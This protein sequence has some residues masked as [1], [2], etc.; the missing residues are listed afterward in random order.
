MNLNK[1]HSTNAESSLPL[2][3]HTALAEV[4][5]TAQLIRLEVEQTAD[6]FP[7]LIT[8]QQQLP[9]QF[10]LQNLLYQ[11]LECISQVLKV[12]TVAVLLLT[13]DEPQQLTVC[14][15]RGLEEEVTAGIRIPLGR[16]FAGN[17][18]AQRQLTII[19]DLSKIEVVSPIL[20][21]K[22]L[23][24]MLGVPLLA[25]GQ[26]IGVFHVGTFRSRR[27]NQEDVT[28]LNAVAERMGLIIDQLAF[29]INDDR[30]RV[31]AT[32]AVVDSRLQKLIHKTA[33]SMYAY[34][35]DLRSRLCLLLY[36]P[37]IL[38]SVS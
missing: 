34:I 7:Q 2:S 14:A 18:A 26:V 22:Q 5:E 4:E 37:Q 28:L 15:A 3:L 25:N 10:I 38:L 21:N 17:V 36:Y 11:L 33:H 27:F 24:S 8:L 9:S 19:D 6:L 32:Q 35:N 23:K 16:G 1:E 30:I 31:Q 13:G 20:R 12:D 29:N